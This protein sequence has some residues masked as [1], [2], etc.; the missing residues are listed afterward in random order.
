IG[1][2]GQ[3]SQAIFSPDGQ[4][5]LTGSADQTARLWNT[6]TG[7][8]VRNLVGHLSPVLYVGFADNGRTVITGDTQNVYR[9]RT[10]LEDTI[11]FTC[12]QL[13][14]DLSRDERTLYRITDNTD[15]CAKFA[16]RTKTPG[17]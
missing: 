5:V 8:L 6:Q 3:V 15:T 1:H 12:S 7:E 11:A 4:Y 2:T 13:T 9:W 17:N 10:T 14:R 16:V